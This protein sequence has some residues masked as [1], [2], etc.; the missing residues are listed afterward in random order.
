LKT[1]DNLLKIKQILRTYSDSKHSCDNEILIE[2]FDSKPEIIIAHI[3]E[4]L[5]I[6]WIHN[7]PLRSGFRTQKIDFYL[8]DVNIAIEYDGEQHFKTSFF[9]SLEESQLKD[10][11]KDRLLN[12]LDIKLIRINYKDKLDRLSI[13]ERIL[14]EVNSP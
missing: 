14:N 13:S 8:P 11:R 9:G 4:H 1:K 10:K 2:Y 3:L 7:H 6:R 12:K 5:G